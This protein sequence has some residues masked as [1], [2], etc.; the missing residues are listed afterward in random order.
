VNL[1]FTLVHLHRA[2]K[3]GFCDSHRALTAVS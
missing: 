3:L 2:R 1:R